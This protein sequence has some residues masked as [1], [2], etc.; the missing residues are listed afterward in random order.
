MAT[1]KDTYIPNVWG[2]GNVKEVIFDNGDTYHIKNTYIPNVWGEGTTQEI[3]KV[4]SSSN[5]YGSV[6]VPRLIAGFLI[7]ALVAII[8][9]GSL[10]GFTLLI[11]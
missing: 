6:S 5:V 11:G 1:I 10:I 3:V 7:I 8:G 9:F 4:N 2:E